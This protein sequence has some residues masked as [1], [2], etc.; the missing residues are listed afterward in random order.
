MFHRIASVA[1][2]R[3]S[4]RCALSTTAAVLRHGGT[5]S[6]SCMR[7]NYLLRPATL[8]SARFFSSTADSSG[9]DIPPPPSS[10]HP[11]A[12]LPNAKGSII[13]T[14]TDEAPAL[15]TYSLYPLISKVS[16]D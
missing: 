3:S 1:A 15:A 5:S 14:E 2:M 16:Q 6:K 10:N 9:I 8:S 12:P 7:S 13:Y 11:H 4:S